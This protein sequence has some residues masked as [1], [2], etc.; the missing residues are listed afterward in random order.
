MPAG[1]MVW[2]IDPRE[3]TG[4]IHERDCAV[5]VLREPE[6]FRADPV[7]PGFECTVSACF[8]D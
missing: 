2:I 6:R 1:G 3:R 4:A 5:R 8:E 7:L